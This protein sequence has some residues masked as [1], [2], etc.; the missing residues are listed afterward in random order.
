MQIRKILLNP[1]N[2]N[3][4]NLSELFLLLADRSQHIQEII[5]PYLKK[6]Y[7]VISD[8]YADS[9]ITYQAAGRNLNMRLIKKLNKL[10]INNIIPDLTF[11]LEADLNVTLQKVK[12]LSKEYNGGDRIEQESINF[13]K[14]IKKEYKNLLKTNPYRIEQIKLKKDINQTQQIIQ[15]VCLRKLKE[16]HFL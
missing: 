13:H 1:K 2:K 12:N 15:N 8:R 10:V 3:L 6:G 11:L 9:T 4:S 7:I 14:K 5:I 16:R